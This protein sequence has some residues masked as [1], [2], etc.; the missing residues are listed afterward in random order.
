M[1]HVPVLRL[2]SEIFDYFGDFSNCKWPVRDSIRMSCVVATVT[3][4][5]YIFEKL[6]PQLLEKLL[7][8]LMHRLWPSATIEECE[9][10]PHGQSSSRHETWLN[11][12]DGAETFRHGQ[13]P[14]GH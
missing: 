2:I 12:E 9:R 1:L 13:D 7:P 5:G 10:S 14:G 11:T 8:H 3:G 6:L 4:I